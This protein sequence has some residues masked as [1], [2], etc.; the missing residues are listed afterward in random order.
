MTPTDRDQRKSIWK[1]VFVLYGCADENG[2]ASFLKNEQ[3]LYPGSRLLH[4]DT[5]G[6]PVQTA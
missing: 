2:V 6:K 4:L 3:Y 5:Y 1:I